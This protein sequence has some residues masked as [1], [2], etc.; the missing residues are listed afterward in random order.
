[1]AG[2]WRLERPPLAYHVPGALKC[3]SL[4]CL[5]EIG[6]IPER[7]AWDTIDELYAR[8]HGFKTQ[9]F[10]DLVAVH[11]RAWGSADGSLRGR[12][13]HGRCAYIVHYPFSWV[14]AR[15][16]R[17]QPTRPRAASALCY[18]GGYVGAAMRRTERVED[19]RF[20]RFMRRELRARMLDRLGAR[21]T[22][23]RLHPAPWPA[24]RADVSRH[25]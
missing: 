17:P 15:A 6:G 24:V 13:R 22:A 1:V 5:E 4:G 3:Y 7:L 12:A 11:H 9:T 19:P 25:V 21:Q 2:Q 8:M 23:A 18:V 10:P 20:R 14:L 16:L